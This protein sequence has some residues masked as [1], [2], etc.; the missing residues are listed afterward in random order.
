MNAKFAYVVHEAS[1]GETLGAP[2]SDARYQRVVEVITADWTPYTVDLWGDCV[3]CKGQTV[4]VENH[5]HT[6]VCQLEDLEGCSWIDPGTID[7]SAVSMELSRLNRVDIESGLIPPVSIG[8]WDFSLYIVDADEGANHG[9]Q[10]R[11]VNGVVVQSE[12]TELL[13]EI[14]PSNVPIEVK[15]YGCRYC[16]R[17]FN[18]RFFYAFGHTCDGW[19]E[20]LGMLAASKAEPTRIRTVVRREAALT[21]HWSEADRNRVPSE[22]GKLQ[23]SERTPKTKFYISIRGLIHEYMDAYS[24]SFH[25]S[26]LRLTNELIRDGEFCA[27]CSDVLCERANAH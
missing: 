3:Q 19:L 6:H 14:G 2:H 27:V 5:T 15:P 25:D 16:K 13:P 18:S 23:W 10:T 20:A 17:R 21:E 11:R 4:R 8:D 12:K 9:R 24:E 1:E 22:L 7:R 26:S